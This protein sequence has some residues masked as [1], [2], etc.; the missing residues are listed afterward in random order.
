MPLNRGN[1]TGLPLNLPLND[2]DGTSLLPKNEWQNKARP[3]SVYGLCQLNREGFCHMGEITRRQSLPPMSRRARSALIA[4]AEET[5]I[6]QAGS[7]AISAVS[8]YA[9]SEVAYL[10]RMQG[11]LEK[12]VPDASEALAMIANTAAL[13]IARSVHRFG[14]EIGG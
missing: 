4:V 6:E 11:E 2:R 8:E 13:S 14:Q 5:Q 12:A 9:M 7:R 1:G 3:K 10:K